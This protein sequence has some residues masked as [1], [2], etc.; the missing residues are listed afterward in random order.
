LAGT[1]EAI[2]YAR[3]RVPNGNLPE[4]RD[5]LNEPVAWTT[6]TVTSTN[7]V[8]RDARLV[9]LER[10][11]LGILRTYGVTNIVSGSLETAMQQ[12]NAAAQTNSVAVMHGVNAVALRQ[13][14]EAMGASIYDCTGEAVRTNVSESVQV[15]P[16]AWRWQQYGF[17]AAPTVADLEKK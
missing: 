17:T 14:I 11:L 2:E 3:Q 15:T 12:M 1:K 9:A 4:I 7:I 6:N 13:Q 16:T 5:V 10:S 8:E